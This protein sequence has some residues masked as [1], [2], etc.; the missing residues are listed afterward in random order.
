MLILEVHLI[1]SLEFGTVVVDYTN[2]KVKLL[3]RYLHELIT[4][5][6]HLLKIDKRLMLELPIFF[7]QFREAN[8]N[9]KVRIRKGNDIREA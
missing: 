3:S 7:C 5:Q 6:L 9:L 8:L 1:D 2:N 4:F